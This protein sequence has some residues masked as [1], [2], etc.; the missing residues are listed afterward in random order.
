VLGLQGVTYDTGGADVKYGGAMAGMHRD[1]CGAAFV[2]GL[3][4]VSFRFS[5][6]KFEI[7]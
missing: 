7:V 2:S 6:S 1:K 3:F 5:G 4:K